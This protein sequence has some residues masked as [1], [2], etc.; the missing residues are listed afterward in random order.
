MEEEGALFYLAR[1]SLRG[2]D[3][4]VCH[5]VDRAVFGFENG[6]EAACAGRYPPNL[7]NKPINTVRSCC[8][9][10]HAAW[11]FF[12]TAA[13]QFETNFQ[14]TPNSP[15]Q[16]PWPITTIIGPNKP[17][18]PTLPFVFSGILLSSHSPPVSTP[19]E[20]CRVAPY[21]SLPAMRATNL[22]SASSASHQYSSSAAAA[23]AAAAFSVF[24]PALLSAAHQVLHSFWHFIG[25]G[26]FL[27]AIILLML[28]ISC[29][30]D[31]N[32]MQLR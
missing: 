1:H 9:S 28:F 29:V 25:L 2:F 10:S 11:L 26:N 16:L 15:N 7:I 21:V 24:D 23:A 3:L 12:G 30:S 5:S 14:S 18:T 32:S 8:F 20:P 19:L 17:N 27:F 13:V 6:A 4:L 31:K 22:S